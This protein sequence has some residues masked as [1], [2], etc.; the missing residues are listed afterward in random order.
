VIIGGYRLNL[1]YSLAH[2]LSLA[3]W[4]PPPAGLNAAFFLAVIVPACVL[5]LGNFYCGYLC[6]FGAL[7][8]L[9]GDL[10]PARLKTV[11]GRELWRWA[12]R[13]KYAL[14]LIVVLLYAATLDPGLAS[15]DPLVTIF[16]KV[17]GAAVVLLVLFVL[18]LSFFFDRFWC[19]ALCPAGAALSLLNGVRALRRFSPKIAPA[20]CP[21]GVVSDR[22]LDCIACDRCRRLREEDARDLRIR[23]AARM[24]RETRLVYLAAVC[25]A[26]LFLLQEAV[27]T[28]QLHRL[29]AATRP[30]A[31][32]AAGQVRNVNLPKLEEMIR[33]R[34][35]SDREA[36]YW[37]PWPTDEEKRPS[38]AAP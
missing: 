5:L 12:R 10:R 14:L 16:S 28:C 13:V 26:A 1:Q 33:Q 27:S 36:M 29:A 18:L 35:L 19:R 8:E 38:A 11:P 31:M 3:G 25:A 9:I 15:S 32:G 21:Y 17:R 23:M 2:V 6:P 4:S 30:A 7:Q 22:D 37:K 34:R 24:G 20:L